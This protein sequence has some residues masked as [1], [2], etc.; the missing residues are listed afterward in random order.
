MR[1]NEISGKNFLPEEN[2]GKRTGRIED[3]KDKIEISGEARE[4][5]EIKRAERVEE[6]RKKIESGFYDSD[7]VINK[8]AE[9]IYK[10][11]KLG[12]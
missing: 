10:F 2:S 5:Y 1:V 7:D 12:M 3:K 4:L 11:F 9:K 8:V 6:I